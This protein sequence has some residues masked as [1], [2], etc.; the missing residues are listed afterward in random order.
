MASALWQPCSSCLLS[1][2]ARRGGRPGPAEPHDRAHGSRSHLLTPPSGKEQHHRRAAAPRQPWASH[3]RLALN[4]AEW[5]DSVSGEIWPPSVTRRSSTMPLHHA[6]L[7]SQP[8]R[9]RPAWT[10]GSG[11][12]RTDSSQLSVQAEPGTESGFWVTVS[13]TVSLKCCFL[14]EKPHNFCLP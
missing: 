5:P 11:T 1:D 4:A 2:A 3:Q 12:M 7:Q 8:G 13:Q 9:T 14:E 10:S 6:Q